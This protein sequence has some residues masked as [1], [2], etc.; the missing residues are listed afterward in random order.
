MNDG[1][2]VANIATERWK[3]KEFRQRVVMNV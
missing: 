1:K 3:T 2:Q